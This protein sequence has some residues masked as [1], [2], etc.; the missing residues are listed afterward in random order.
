MSEAPPATGRTMPARAA[1]ACSLLT[2]GV[3]SAVLVGWA[4]GSATLTSVVPGLV[5][6]NPL[7]AV[8][9]VGCGAAI[10]IWS[11]AAVGLRRWLL[12]LA[13][14]LVGLCGLARLAG[15]VFGW[16]LPIDRIIFSDQLNAQGLPNRMAPNTAFNFC[17]MGLAF[18]VLAF[19]RARLAQF[20]AMGAAL[21]AFVAVLG[22]AYSITALVQ[23][24]TF[25]PMALHTA[26]LFL[27]LTGAVL[28]ATPGDGPMPMITGNTAGSH[29]VRRMLPAMIFV[30]PV[31]GW[32]RIQGEL[33]GWYGPSLGVALTVAAMVAGGIALTWV[34]ARA[35][36]QGDA[37]RRRADEIILRMAHFDNLTGL[38]NR[39]L[40]ED[41]LRLA[42]FRAQR[43]GG[44]VA[45]MF[46]DLDGFK[47]VNDRLGHA[48][49]DSVLSE[50]AQRMTASLRSV[51]TA[52]R[53]GGDEFTIVL[54]QIKQEQ[55][56]EMVAQRL[57]D[58]LSRPYVVA[59]TE[60]KLS[61][62]AG[63]SL[64]PRDS[65][66]ASELLSLADAAMY[67]AKRAG[68]NQVMFHGMNQRPS[69]HAAGTR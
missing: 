43:S 63:V 39:T 59:G 34:T 58:Q 47:A 33:A 56:V 68:K 36:N 44:T 18:I 4:I 45:L 13:G 48:A 53:L 66:T 31:L 32:L 1:V 51:D 42:L 64:F 40:F 16:N 8:C 20:L 22:Y 27:L 10:S 15:Y 38:P 28:C 62:S 60:A 46:L 2:I 50:A 37:E 21:T 41:R 35:V 69:E 26:I 65:M 23:V 14:A 52:A 6:M 9:F 19:G 55:D 5:A 30:P 54:E 25:I 61:A 29:V 17:L 11:H 24:A 67:R 12:A 3:A 49:G 7:T 57:L